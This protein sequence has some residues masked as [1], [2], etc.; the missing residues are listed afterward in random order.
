[1]QNLA[2]VLDA[3]ITPT[4][5]GPLSGRP[6]SSSGSPGIADR[7]YWANDVDPATVTDRG[8][9]MGQ[10]FRDNGGGWDPVGPFASKFAIGSFAPP[11]ANGNFDITTVGFQPK[12]VKF[13]MTY[14]DNSDTALALGLGAAVSP[15]NRRCFYIRSSSGEFRRRFYTARC[16]VGLDANATLVYSADLVSMLA[17]GFRLVFSSI[18]GGFVAANHIIAWEA[19]G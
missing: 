5:H 15:T 8:G 14:N 19:Y 9:V 7:Q 12:L 6:T 11:S 13:T 4:T 17:N 3:M 10:M 1:M 18:A 2:T 16:A